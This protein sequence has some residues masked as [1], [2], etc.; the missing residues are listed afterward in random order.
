MITQEDSTA[1]F[2]EDD[3][4][5]D[6]SLKQQLE[7]VAPLIRQVSGS[8]SINRSQSSPYGD[9]RDMLWLG[10]CYARIL[11]IIPASYIDDTLPDSSVYFEND[12]TYT[13]FPQYLRRV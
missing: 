5:W 7:R 11:Y 10:H 4:D 6:I 13:N 12:G 8:S 3:V 9:A 1:L 2:M